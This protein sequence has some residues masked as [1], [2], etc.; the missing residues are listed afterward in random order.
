MFLDPSVPPDVCI[1]NAQRVLQILIEC[2]L[3]ADREK[4]TTEAVKDL[5]NGVER[6]LKDSAVKDSVLQYMSWP[7]FTSGTTPKKS[8]QSASYRSWGRGPW[9]W[10]NSST[11][12]PPFGMGRYC[13]FCYTNGHSEDRCFMKIAMAKKPKT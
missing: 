1:K 5:H 10:N 13:T 12:R 8:S 7:T 2:T 6:V 9:N 3:R 4:S 11:V